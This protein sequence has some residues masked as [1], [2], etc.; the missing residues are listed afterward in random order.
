VTYTENNTQL[1]IPLYPTGIQVEPDPYLEF[2]Y[3][4]NHIVYSQDP[5]DPNPDPIE[6]FYLG[7]LIQNA[8]GGTAHSL[9]I[10]SA[11]PTLTNPKGLDILFSIIGTQVDNQPAAP[12]LTADLGDIAPNGGTAT[13]TFENDVEP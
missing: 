10:T 4:L 7:L 5:F 13:A 12:S 6:P 1:S 3:L 9:T 2:H 8:G 11:Q